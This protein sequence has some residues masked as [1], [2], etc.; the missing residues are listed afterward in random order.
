[1]KNHQHMQLEVNRIRTIAEVDEE[2][3]ERSSMWG[4]CS[5]SVSKNGSDGHEVM[6][7]NSNELGSF[8]WQ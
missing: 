7:T 6:H 3:E 8:N 4:G 1:M 2:F 5:E